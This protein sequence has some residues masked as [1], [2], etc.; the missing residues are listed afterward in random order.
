[1]ATGFSDENLQEIFD[2]VKD[3][4]ISRSGKSVR[5][6]PELVFEVGYAEIQKS[7]NYEGGYA[8]R[9]PRFIRIRDDKS[10]DQVETLDQ[11]RDRY[12]SRF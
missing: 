4:V 3:S 10:V 1:V 8:L 5:F 9:F 6:E 12:D 11:I 7:P 2:L